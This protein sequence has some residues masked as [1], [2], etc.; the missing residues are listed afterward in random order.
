MRTSRFFAVLA[1]L[2]LFISCSQSDQL[3]VKVEGGKIKGV[4]SQASD[5]AVFKGI[6]YAAPPVGDLRWKKPQPVVAWKGVRDCSE[7]GNIS[8]QLGH[9]EGSFYWKEFYYSAGWRF[10]RSE[11]NACRYPG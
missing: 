4:T 3:V 1:V 8:I 10:C 5:V 6:P 11:G 9:D 2:A 7:F